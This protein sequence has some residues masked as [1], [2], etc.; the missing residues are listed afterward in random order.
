M[1]NIPVGVEEACSGVRSLQSTIMAAFFF[2]ELL[3]FPKTLRVTLLALAIPLAFTLNWLR[4][5]TLTLAAHWGGKEQLDAWHDIAGNTAAVGGFVLVLVLAWAMQ[6]FVLGIQNIQAPPEHNDSKAHIVSTSRFATLYII[7][8]LSFIASEAWYLQRNTQS[9]ESYSIS[10][11]WD[12]L[13]SDVQFTDIDENTRAILRYSEG[14]QAH[15]SSSDQQH[16]TAFYF[17]WE[18]GMISSFAGVHSPEACLPAA[19]FELDSEL[20]PFLWETQVGLNIQFKTYLFKTSNKQP[21]YVFF[22]VWDD[23]PSDDQGEVSR[24]AKGRL[25][26][27]WNALRIGGRR[28]LEFVIQNTPS[29]EDA[30][31]AV[32]EFMQS[33]VVAQKDK[34]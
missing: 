10:V 30:R 4:T 32:Y 34:N 22:A 31:L 18:P 21:V 14:T 17:V 29:E 13:R 15:W 16:W 33:A 27:A 19:G 7:F 28:Q 9:L 5:L 23:T 11:N 8:A 6:R 12:K 25:T 3:K 1:A 20:K 24:T 26:Q 2:G